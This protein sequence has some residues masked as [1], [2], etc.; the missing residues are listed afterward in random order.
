MFMLN[1]T[2]LVIDGTK[3]GENIDEITIRNIELFNSVLSNVNLSLPG[4]DRQKIFYIAVAA[5]TVGRVY[6]NGDV[7][8]KFDFRNVNTL[9]ATAFYRIGVNLSERISSNFDV[10]LY[11]AYC[12]NLFNTAF[13]SVF[14]PG[15]HNML[16]NHLQASLSPKD[17]SLIVD[18]IDLYKQYNTI[19][20]IK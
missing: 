7:A 9:M 10:N 14:S 13:S 20:N 8:S 3:L 17:Y 11:K 18:N 5:A 15:K 16:I 12:N 4:S 19:A 6:Y 1:S 2:P